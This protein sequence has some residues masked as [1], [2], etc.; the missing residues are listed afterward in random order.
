MVKKHLYNK[1]RQVQQDNHEPNPHSLFYNERI[2]D[3]VVLI[4]ALL[5]IIGILFFY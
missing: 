2:E 4:L 1:K 5:I 3:Y